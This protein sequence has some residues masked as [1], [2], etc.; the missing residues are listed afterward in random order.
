MKEYQIELKQLVDYPRCRIYRKF[1]QALIA[2]RSLH[3]NGGCGLFYFM[4]LYSLVNFRSSYQRIEKTSY[5]VHPGEW[6]CPLHELTENFRL[7]YQKQT[8]VILE[9]LQ[10]QNYISFSPLAGGRLIKYKIIGWEK[11]NTA[12]EYNAPCQKD[13]GFFFFPIAAAKEL[14]SMRKCSEMDIVLDLWLNTVY[15]DSRVQGSDIG[16]VVYYRSYTGNPFI[17]YREL[18]ERWNVSRS[19]VSRLLNKLARMEYLTLVSGT[20]K[21]G[22]VLYLNN[23]LSTMFQISDVLIDKEEVAMSLCFNIQTQDKPS[24]CSIEEEQISVSK[25]VSCVSKTRIQVIV[26]KVA[27]I[28]SAQ[29]ISCGLCRNSRYKLYPYPGACEE[30]ELMELELSCLG[31]SP[32]YRFELKIL[33]IEKEK[34]YEQE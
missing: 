29:G 2:D 24:E 16:P 5:I 8:L 25:D 28:L 14:I 11:S 27:E 1:L 20:G 15:K 26:S 4:V 18:A 3:S 32:L 6:I 9:Y 17:S 10:R 33:A 12:L 21:T 23:Y 30:K 7:K 34:K 13:T 22:S 31:S 19:T